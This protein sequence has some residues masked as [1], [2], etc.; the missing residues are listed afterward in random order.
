MR[1][2]GI[3]GSRFFASEVAIQPGSRGTEP[4]HTENLETETGN[5][6]FLEVENAHE[7]EII[8]KALDSV[9]DLLFVHPYDKGLIIWGTNSTTGKKD[10]F[11]A[12]C[13]AAQSYCKSPQPRLYTAEQFLDLDRGAFEK[14]VKEATGFGVS[15]TP[16]KFRAR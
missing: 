10:A 2:V 3:S 5:L 7:K 13:K 14:I 15:S 4:V 6:I 11:D 9:A 12:L 1:I 8:R 16:I